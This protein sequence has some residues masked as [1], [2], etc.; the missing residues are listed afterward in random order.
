[1]KFSQLK[2]YIF[3]LISTILSRYY[4]FDIN[5][6]NWDETTYF[7]SGIKILQGE[8]PYKDF[9]ELKPPLTFYLYS[10][11][12]YF[13]GEN[14]ISF[15]I[16]SV[17][18]VFII[19]CQI[20][21]ILRNFHSSILDKFLPFLFILVI[22]YFFWGTLST[23][24]IALP[25]LLFSYYLIR[26][27]N[28][29]FSGFMLSLATLVRLNLVYLVIG[30][31]LYLIMKII[32][33][34]IHFK[35]LLE[36]L[37]GGTIPLCFFIIYFFHL[38]LF[39]LFWVSN[40]NVNLV[41]LGEKS[42]LQTLF[43][44]IKSIIKLNFFF[45][46]HFLLF[47][48]L[49]IFGLFYKIS[50]KNF[51]LEKVFLFYL[52]S[53]LFS[54]LMTKQGYTHHLILSIPFLILFI[55]DFINQCR[56]IIFLSFQSVIKYLI[57]ISL[58]SQIYI[59]N[60]I[61]SITN[62]LDKSAIIKAKI[63]VESNLEFGDEILALDYHLLNHYLEIKTKTPFIHTPS[64]NRKT[65]KSRLKPLIGLGF[66]EKNHINYI[67]KQKYKFIICSKRICHDKVD[68]YNINRLKKIFKHYE[69]VLEIKDARLWEYTKNTNLII[70]KRI[71]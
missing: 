13:F 26:V 39:D 20:Y 67:F 36:Y 4:L 37:I 65:T 56:S 42:L 29:F 43:E 69:K 15:R 49:I 46:Y 57:V 68:S 24:L 60:S 21:I 38:N 19:T 34:E 31:V 66:I 55:S 27:K 28:F 44:I 61:F 58:L 51:N 45:P 54:I 22:S 63:F 11:P 32:R 8:I 12:L 62:D 9:W 16:W 41:Y 5:S 7:I 6:I 33:K 30:I 52:I 10:I 2:I 23:E 25:F 1:M 35:S 3:F 48:S 70:Y 14:L 18:I 53:I 50:N 47:F 40:V 59:S 71:D 64:L 17:I